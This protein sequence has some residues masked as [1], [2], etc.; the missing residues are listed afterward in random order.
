MCMSVYARARARVCGYIINSKTS[1]RS[2]RSLRSHGLPDYSSFFFSFS[3][4]FL[5]F[6]YLYLFQEFKI[7]RL[8][9]I[10]FFF[11]LFFHNNCIQGRMSVGS[12]ESIVL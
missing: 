9:V 1:A 7:F 5:I 3:F 12:N 8:K 6:S 4:L 11:F 2:L 10:E